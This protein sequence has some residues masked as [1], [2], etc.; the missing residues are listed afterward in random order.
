M[1]KRL[2]TGSIILL[3]YALVLVSARFTPYVF[4]IFIG[5]LAVMGAV[6]VTRVLERKKLY[7]NIVFIGCFPAILY[8]AMQIG[9]V[10]ERSWVYFIAYFIAV[11]LILFVVNF[12]YT[13]IFRKITRRE[14]LRGTQCTLWKKII[15]QNS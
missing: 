7:T 3:V 9:I 8:I 1:K 10:N 15:N 6:E 13:I 4:D 5:V 12:L 11:I 2:M 14:K